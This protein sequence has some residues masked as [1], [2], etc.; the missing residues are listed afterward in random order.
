MTVTDGL[1]PDIFCTVTDGTNSTASPSPL[2]V[3]CTVEDETGLASSPVMYTSALGSDTLTNSSGSTYEGIISVE[4]VPAGSYSIAIFATDAAANTQ[5]YTLNPTVTDAIAPTYTSLS[6]SPSSLPNDGSSSFVVSATTVY[7]ETAIAAISVTIDGTEYTM[8]DAD[9]DSTYETAAITPTADDPWPANTYAVDLVISDGTNQTTGSTTVDVTDGVSPTVSSCSATTAS[10]SGSIDSTFTAVATDETAV[11]T[12]SYT[13]DFGSDV[14]SLS[15]GSTYTKS[16]DLTGVAAGT[17]SVSFY[18]TDAAGNTSSSCTASFILL[19]TSDPAIICTLGSSSIA[20]DGD[21]TTLDCVV[22]EETGISSVSYSGFG[23]GSL[24][25]TSRTD[26]STT[27]TASST[28]AA[29]TYIIPVTVTDTSDNTDSYSVTLPVTD[30]TA[31]TF[32]FVHAIP[33]SILDDGTQTTQVFVCMDDETTDLNASGSVDITID[34]YTETLPY[35]SGSGCFFSSEING[36]AFS[37]GTYTI[38][39]HAED[40]AENSTIDISASLEVT[41]SAISVSNVT[42]SESAMY[43]NNTPSEF[44]VSADITAG[45]CS[46]SVDTSSLEVTIDG[47]TNSMSLNSGSTYISETFDAW[48]MDLGAYTVSI[49]GADTAGYTTTNT[50]AT[51]TI[52]DICDNLAIDAPTAT[53]G[54]YIAG[55]YAGGLTTFS[56]WPTLLSSASELNLGSYGTEFESPVIINYNGAFAESVDLGSACVGGSTSGTTYTTSSYNDC[57]LSGVYDATSFTLSVAF[58]TYGNSSPTFAVNSA[59]SSGTGTNYFRSGSTSYINDGAG[60]S[61]ALST[62]ASLTRPATICINF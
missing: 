5:T 53:V 42:A 37:A 52:A 60:T 26:Y 8:A 4:G 46:G 40:A 13:A 7:D 45:S 48:G 38:A 16:V 43:N 22:S 61:A 30:A 50:S 11:S 44:T 56:S 33:D 24:T 36:N 9:G 19:D 27:L 55:S 25:A 18:A 49:T 59:S 17:K 14:L 58:E 51:I 47:T 62:Y 23:S 32:T 15:S 39:V 2:E 10:N 21:S 6:S 31:P 57:A 3:S 20:N 1:A 28:T 12:V 41:C 54:V 34:S 29:G 35:D